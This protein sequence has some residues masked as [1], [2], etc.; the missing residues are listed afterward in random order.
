MKHLYLSWFL[1]VAVAVTLGLGG[2][3]R[4][5][6][7]Y[8][9]TGTVKMDNQPVADARVVFTDASLGHSA[10][11]RTDAAGSFA[12]SYLNK[13][14]APEG[15]YKVSISKMAASE[16]LK[17]LFVEQVPARYNKAT[18]LTAQVQKDGAN[19]FSFDHLTSETD[20]LDEKEAARPVEQT[21]S[22]A[23]DKEERDP[24]LDKLD[25]SR[26]DR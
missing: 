18:Q 2:C 20:E 8:P 17:G 13:E 26:D 7:T 3:S 10:V 6:K 12:L 21:E 23:D 15:N 24:A 4:G 16:E 14:G 1:L 11:G 25:R 19:V 22:S 5:P 9:V